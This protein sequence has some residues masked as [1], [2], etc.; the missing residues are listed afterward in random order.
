[1][2]PEQFASIVIKT[3]SDGQVTYLRDVSRSELGARSQD[4][5]CRLDGKPS[6]GLAVFQLPPPTRSTP[7]ID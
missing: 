3:G 7:P 2:E 5:L 1:M 6:V 4:T